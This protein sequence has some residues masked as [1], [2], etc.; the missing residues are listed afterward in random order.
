[1][2]PHLW[3]SSAGKR[4][5][6]W[7]NFFRICISRKSKIFAFHRLYCFRLVNGKPFRQPAGLPPGQ[8][9]GFRSVAGPLELPIIQALPREHEPVPVEVKCFHRIFPAST[10]QKDRIGER[11]H[12]EVIPDDCHEPVK[13]FPHIRPARDQTDFLYSGQIAGQSSRRADTVLWITSLPAL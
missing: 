12:P 1:M 7:K 2:I 10:E 11:V 13:G 3:I 5:R 9:P 8:R 4:F 6:L